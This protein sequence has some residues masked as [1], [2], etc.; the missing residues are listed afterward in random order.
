VIRRAASE[1]AAVAYGV[2]DAALIMAPSV[3]LAT[4][5]HQGGLPGS[6]GLDLVAASA[7]IATVDGVLAWARLRGETRT[8][9][10]RADV[11]IAAV[12]SL[13]VLALG[14]TLLMIAVLGG[15]AEEHA[16]IINEGWPVL[17][18]WVGVLLVAVTLS[19]L[20]GR[21]VFRWL[22][23]TTEPVPGR[24]DV[25]VPADVAARAI[26]RVPSAAEE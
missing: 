8:A 23:P 12:D 17:A 6:H 2:V 9:T 10:R 24:G 14:A 20:A 3:V 11:W 21:A 22:E 19:E 15:F 16:A 18:L 4:S 13:V 26:A 1:V 7:V 25:A 5:A